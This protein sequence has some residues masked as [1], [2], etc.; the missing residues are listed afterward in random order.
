MSLD[1]VELSKLWLSFVVDLL[2][3]C[4]YLSVSDFKKISVKRH[5]LANCH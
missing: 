1:F 2:V 5:L 3:A 4:I